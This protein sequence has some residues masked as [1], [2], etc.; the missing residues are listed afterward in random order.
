MRQQVAVATAQKHVYKIHIHIRGEL[1][2]SDG[3][4]RRLPCSLVRV[5]RHL[6]ET[7]CLYFPPCRWPLTLYHCS[8]LCATA[9]KTLNILDPCSLLETS[10]ELLPCTFLWTAGQCVRDGASRNEPVPS[11]AHRPMTDWVIAAPGGASLLPREG[12][13]QVALAAAA[14][15]TATRR[16]Q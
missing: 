1:W 8:L 3:G 10:Y 14:A 13:S 16:R 6:V 9:H 15:A 2:G 4:D 12:G 11:S 5:H 7:Y